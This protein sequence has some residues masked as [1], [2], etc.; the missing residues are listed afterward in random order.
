MS[1]REFLRAVGGGLVVAVSLDPLSALAQPRWPRY[2]EDLNVYLRIGADG[3]VTAFSGKIEMGQ[4]VLTSQAQLVA[5]ELRV[6]LDAVELVLGDTDRC[7]WD[8]GTFGSLTTRMFGPALRAAAAEARTVLVKLASERL[9]IP[10]ERLEAEDGAVRVAAEPGRKVGYGDL[11]RGHPLARL[12]G[13]KAVLR[14]AKDFTVMGRS[15]TRLD[16]RDKVAGRARYAG[17]VRLPGML[18]ARILRPPAHGA[19]LSSVDVSA[20]RKRPG[21]TVVQ[22]KDLLAVLHADPEAAEAALRAVEARW[23]V[24]RRDVDPDTIFDHLV[25]SAPPA[26]VKGERGDPAGARKAAARLFDATYR[27]GYRAHA[28]MEPHTALAQWEKG[29]MTVWAS[30]QTPFP[31]RD[32]VAQALGLSPKAVRI[33]TPFVGGGFGGKSAGGQVVEA[34]RLARLTGKPVQVAWTRAEEFFLDTFAPAAVVRIVSALGED[35]KISLW[36]YTVHASGDRSTELFYDVPNAAIRVHGGWMGARG[37][38]HLFAVGPWRAPGAPTNV[39]AGESHVDVMAAAARQDPLAFRVR[40]TSDPRMRRVLET[41][42]RAAGWKPGAGPT[43]RGRGV[44]CAVDAGTDVAIVAEVDVD[45]KTG[46]VRVTRVVAAQ[47]MGIVVNPE[48]A[49]MQMEG[50]VTMGLGYVLSE[51]LRFKGGEILDRSFDTYALP[52]FSWLPRIETVL[53]KNDDLAPQGGGEPAIV[54]LGAAVGNAIFDATG[55]RLERLPM[56]PARVLEA[57]AKA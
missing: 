46:R 51:E 27:T 23:D 13:G 14:A 3:R 30:T 36:D 34:A 18:H 47:D 21:V 8:M 33:V 54:P 16:A 31:A 9:G 25:A 41:A 5:E 57:L 45:R 22:E 1:R 49:R 24:P 38:G 28:P 37:N 56:T 53:V 39:F 50:C 32:A 55:A 15:P 40:N 2:P 7:P 48:G 43:G 29:K 52:R 10:P 44:A 20:A 19:T 4:G 12:V 6:P 11:A 26:E 17:D 42:A 35:G